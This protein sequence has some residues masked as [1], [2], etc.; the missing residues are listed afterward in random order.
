[1]R[2]SKLPDPKVL[3][4]AGSFFMNPVV[5]RSQFEQIH[6]EYP[7]MPFY[8]V[9]DGIKIPAGWLIE[10]C[11]WKGKALGKAGVYEKQALVIVNH[12]GATSQ[13]IVAL[14]DAICKSVKEKFGVEIH[15]E[16]NFI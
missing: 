2:N 1:M 14:S 10:N 3:G 7:D 16:V 8:E 6:S 13:D 12:G 11:G 9:A 15:P 5:S 4:N